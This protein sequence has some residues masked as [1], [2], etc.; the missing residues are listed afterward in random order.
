[1]SVKWAMKQKPCCWGC[2][3]AVSLILK[4]DRVGVWVSST[5]K[6]SDYVEYEI[7]WQDVEQRWYKAI[8]VALGTSFNNISDLTFALRNKILFRG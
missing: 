1:M 4:V 3:F 7:V 6:H 5:G 8:S 2:E